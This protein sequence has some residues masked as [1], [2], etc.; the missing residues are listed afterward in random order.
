MSRPQYLWIALLAV[1]LI[2]THAAAQERIAPL[3]TYDDLIGVLMSESELLAWAG[4]RTDAERQEF[5]DVFWEERDPTPGTEA[6]EVR[7]I[8]ERR[9]ERAARLF[10]EGAVPGYSTDRGRVMIVFGLPDSQEM[11]ALPTEGEPQLMWLYDREPLNDGILLKDGVVGFERVDDGYLLSSVVD[12]DNRMFLASLESELRMQLARSVGGYDE[13]IADPDAESDEDDD[14]PD[15]A[16]DETDD[17]L[18]AAIDGAAEGEGATEGDGAAESDDEDDGPP[19]VRVS[20]EVQVWM[21]LVFSGISR[22]ELKLR[23][24]FHYFPASDATYTVLSFK[25]GKES[26]AFVIPEED[27][28]DETEPDDETDASDEIEPDDEA[29]A[30]DGTEPDDETDAN[31]QA[32]AEETDGSDNETPTDEAVDSETGDDLLTDAIADELVSEAEPDESGDEQDVADEDDA[33]D[34]DVDDEDADEPKEPNA[35]LKL[36]GAVLQGEPGN[37]DTIHRFVIPY[38]LGESEGDDRESP[39]LSLGVSLYPGEYRLAWG[40]LDETSG[41]AVTRD[42]SFTVP[43]FDV[44]ELTLTR[45]LMARPPHISDETAIDPRTIYQGLRLGR[46][47]VQD[48]LDRN[49]GRDD[50]VDVI[51]LASGWSS[52]PGAPGK[53]RLE[54]QYRLLAGLEGT[55]SLATIPPQVLDFHVLGQQIPLAQ[56]N[57]LEPG[58]DYRIEVIVRDLVSGVERIV[59]TPFH[60]EPANEDGESQ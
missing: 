40:I 15:D 24:R 27:E 21:Q 28:T 56:V 30:D 45:P 36:F 1:L 26:M 3:A 12:L 41:N 44:D 25:I 39:T 52:D 5:A 13:A 54:V 22:D 60:L 34:Q 17:E 38:R 37:E 49:F 46:M 55:R 19:P 57:R 58:R 31:G 6:N 23:H 2:V 4:L 51:L 7:R 9:A 50:I 11:R 33:D 16:G 35:H 47:V 32:D 14:L 53:P 59:Q 48:D 18:S 42:E 20:P 29:D 8:F 43:S 10:A